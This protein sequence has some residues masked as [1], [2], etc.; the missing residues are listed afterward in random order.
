MK[1]SPSPA[2]RAGLAWCPNIPRLRE[3]LY[4]VPVSRDWYGGARFGF[5]K[6]GGEVR[7][8]LL[9]RPLEMPAFFAHLVAG[10]GR[11][12]SAPFGGR[13]PFDSSV[14]GP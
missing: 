3:E 11:E 1:R 2:A 7:G 12:V 6:R 10:G 4:E 8:I 13:I 5:R 14:I 9:V